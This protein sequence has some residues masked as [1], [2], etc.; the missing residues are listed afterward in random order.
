MS[1]Y[2]PPTQDMLLI[3]QQV[4]Q[5]PSQLQAFAP[6]AQVDAD[7]VTQVVQEAGKFVGEVVAPLSRQ[8]DEVGAQ[9][10]QG[11]VTM[12]PGFK[13]AYQAFW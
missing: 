10:H 5:A 3:L 2:H 13:D 4:L 8:G 7:L 11:T 6:F 1:L 12:P 9:W